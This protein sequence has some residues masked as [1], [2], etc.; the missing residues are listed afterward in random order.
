MQTID[1]D[2]GNWT[3][4]ID[5]YNSVLARVGA[6]DWH[7]HSVSALIDSMVWGGINKVEQPYVIRVHDTAKLPP[8]V[9]DEVR[10]VNRALLDACNDA[11]GRGKNIHVANE[12]DPPVR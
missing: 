11:R 7:G 9:L 10:I 5:F 3:R 12:M 4:P 2:A 6:P 1:I 8:D